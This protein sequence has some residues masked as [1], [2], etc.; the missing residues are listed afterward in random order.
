M[1]NSEVVLVI[2]R[3]FAMDLFIHEVW[4]LSMEKFLIQLDMVHT[5][6]EKNLLSKIY[7]YPITY[8]FS[9]PGI[10]NTIVI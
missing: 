7:T 10:T 2:R 3:L 6:V 1:F 4:Q 5:Y 9:G 8:I